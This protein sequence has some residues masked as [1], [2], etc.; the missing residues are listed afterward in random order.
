MKRSE[1]FC[2]LISVFHKPF[3]MPMC[4][5]TTTWGKHFLPSIK[6][7]CY[8]LVKFIDQYLSLLGGVFRFSCVDNAVFRRYNSHIWVLCHLFLFL[9][10]LHHTE[11]PPQCWVMVDRGKAHIPSFC[12]QGEQGV[13][14]HLI[15]SNWDSHRSLLSGQSV[16][17]F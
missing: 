4:P 2:P 6:L 8:D 13:L 7:F 1:T 9:A 14:H 11:A 15:G 16:C 3:S 17:F 12:L 5:C 10:F